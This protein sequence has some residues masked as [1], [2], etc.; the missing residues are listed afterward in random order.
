[1]IAAVGDDDNGTDSGS[2]YVFVR[3]GTERTQQAKL[4]P[5][6]GS[7]GEAFNA[8]AIDGDTA[9]VGVVG[10]D[11]NG[12]D[13]GAAYVFVR[14]GTSWTQQEKLVAS[15]GAPKTS[16]SRSLSTGIRQ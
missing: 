11:D 2:A 6:D 9:M 1:M 10:D 12:T 13:S 16:V 3:S 4:L 5:S 15:D 8:I 14:S 7:A